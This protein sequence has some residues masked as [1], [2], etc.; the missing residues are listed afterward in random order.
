MTPNAPWLLIDQGNTAIKWRMADASGLS[1]EGGVVESAEGLSA[2]LKALVWG[3]VGLS[4]VGS[5]ETRSALAHTLLAMSAAP[6][7]T[8]SS[9]RACLGLRNSYAEPE[10]MGVDRWLAMLAVRDGGEGAFCVI[11]AGT[12]VTV[13]I[14]TA[15]GQHEGGYIF[16]GPELMRRA[17]IS[18]TG[19][20]RADAG[21]APDLAPGQSTIDCVNAGVWRAA[22][23]CVQSVMTDYPEHHAI[24]T[25]GGAAGLLALG[26]AADFR[27]DLVLQGLWVWLS[28][29][30][31][32]QRA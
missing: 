1:T 8:A 17:L 16:P 27:P 13:D 24:L 3:A 23:A 18:D 5:D 14:V 20:I 15:E 30:L 28:R 6:V 12:A 9:E 26:V 11:D 19:R 4:S 25:G 7:F 29:A 10:L 31:D 21:L 22:C 2:C 32:D